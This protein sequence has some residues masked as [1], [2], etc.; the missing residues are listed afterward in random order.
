MV[1]YTTAILILCLSFRA[2]DADAQRHRSAQPQPQL[3]RSD[4]TI[5]GTTLEVYQ[6]YQPEL[7]PV[8]KPEFSP[9]LPPADKEPAP[10]QYEVPQQ[11]LYYSYRSL[12]LRPLALGKDTGKLPPQNYALLGGGN[13]STMLAEVGL[14]NLSGGNWN[15]ALLGR[16]VSQEGKIENQLYRSF[17]V[18]GSGT[19]QTELHLLE[20]GL[21]V[22]RNVFGRYGYNHDAASYKLDDVRMPYNAANISFGVRNT[23]PGP[24]GIDYHPKIDIGIF[25]ARQGHETTINLW[26]P[27]IKHLDASLSLLFA[28][29]GQFAWTTI[30]NDKGTNHILQF[31]PAIGFHSGD[32]SGHIGLYPTVGVGAPV[33]VLPDIQASYSLLA[34]KLSLAAGWQAQRLQNTLQQLTKAN[35][36]IMPD[37][38]ARMQTLRHEV[39]AT[40][41]LALG[42]HM[43]VWGR[44]AWQRHDPLALFITAPAG[45][46][47]DFI[48]VYDN[49]VQAFVWG[50]G[51]RY[52][53][54]EDFSIGAE[55]SWY[56]F[57]Q[58]TFAHVWG[59]P[60]VR[61]KGDAS[62]RIINGLM[63]TTYAEVLDKIWG[64]DAL[65]EDVQQRG[66]FDFGASGEYNFAST[67]SVFVRAENLLGRK[68]E[69]WLGYPSFGFNLYGGLRF[70]F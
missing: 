12:P 25:D 69:R 67:L 64:H 19:Y 37:S 50:G 65:G 42:K 43:S 11:T 9:T 14:G 21:D 61:L 62:L 8:V 57:Y 55:G 30:G 44:A 22:R 41:K 60:S 51:I 7:K 32:F 46:G 15:A 26:L 20:G 49:N 4:T 52:A 17:S 56:N 5:K 31:V 27:A 45:D 2:I 53:I 29:N 70:R 13:L 18:F 1:K 6:V 39:F 40:A 47:K 35:P 58:H 33:Q 66:V 38:S 59:E 54:G 63:L 68:N 24:W 34:K 48:V 16:Y 3:K 10:Q 28:I 23:Q 36:Y